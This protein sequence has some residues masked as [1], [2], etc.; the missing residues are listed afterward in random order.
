MLKR[1]GVK[2]THKLNVSLY[3]NLVFL[4]FCIFLPIRSF[5]DNSLPFSPPAY[6]VKVVPSTNGLYKIVVSFN[7][8]SSII[9]M[10]NL[11]ENELDSK[12]G[13]NNFGNSLIGITVSCGSPCFNTTFY[14]LQSAQV[15]PVAFFLPF[16]VDSTRGL[17]AYPKD[18][19]NE[20]I[21]ANIFKP[22]NTMTIKRNFSPIDTLAISSIV[23]FLKDKPAIQF[24]Y[25]EGPNYVGKSEI[26]PLDFSALGINS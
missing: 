4:F 1:V 19:E 22:N 9:A 13:F 3:A 5:A 6:G 17:V 18:A 10:D 14:N 25:P 15:S 7:N 21:I 2:M 26:I 20:L 16:A 24:E 11:D 8:G 12:I 23:T